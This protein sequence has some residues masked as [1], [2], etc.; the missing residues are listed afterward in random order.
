M[1]DSLRSKLVDTLAGI[2]DLHLSEAEENSYPY[3]VYDLTSSPL[4]DK[5]GVYAYSG[6]TTIRIV[7]DV[8]KEIDDIRSQVESAI[9]SQM[10]GEVFSSRLND[11]TKEC[12]GGIWTIELTYTLKQYA[13]WAQ[14]TPEENVQTNTD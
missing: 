14:P 5:D 12:T 8:F 2:I 3:A 4:M 11:V 7:G 6:D 1:I 9:L 13:D 10:H